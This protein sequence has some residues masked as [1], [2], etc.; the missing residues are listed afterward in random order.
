MNIIDAALIAAEDKE[1]KE[2]KKKKGAKYVAK[3]EIEKPNQPDVIDMTGSKL[4]SKENANKKS[5]K[6]S[7]EE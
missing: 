5:L 6:H 2:K 4:E 3:D 1:S 7:K